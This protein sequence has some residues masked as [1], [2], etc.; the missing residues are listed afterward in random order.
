MRVLGESAKFKVICAANRKWAAENYHPG[1]LFGAAISA[2]V[3]DVVRETIKG[4]SF[5]FGYGID[6]KRPMIRFVDE[7]SY[8][9]K[10]V[11]LAEYLK[12][13]IE[14]YECQLN[15]EIDGDP[16]DYRFSRFMLEAVRYFMKEERA[17]R[18]PS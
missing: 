7:D 10:S 5:S 3:A 4:G 12:E 14:Y 13:K 8:C 6:D 17:G 11:P 2:V 9:E 1:D 15:P 18:T 16:V